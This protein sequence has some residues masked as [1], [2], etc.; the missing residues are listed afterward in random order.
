MENLVLVGFMGTGKT[1]VGK[2]IARKLDMEYV[3][4]DTLIEQKEGAPIKDI[5]DKK[6]EDYFRKIEKE[7]IAEVSKKQKAAIDTGG[8]VVINSSNV[9][10]L[11]K[12]GIIFCLN[13]T[14]KEI[15]ERTKKYIHRPLLNVDDPLKEIKRLLEAR[16]EH[17]KKADY[18]IDTTGK[19]ADE[20]SA[21][22]IA[23]YNRKN[24]T[25]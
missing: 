19:N 8:G 22:I 17:Y 21:K 10:D 4:T 16:K 9:R 11:K 14:P 24:G 5:F 25:R 6:G 13:A 3:N 23:I 18:Q 15:L 20:V 12:N 7:I 1:C 2:L